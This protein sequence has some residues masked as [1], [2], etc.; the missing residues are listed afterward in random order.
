MTLS[1]I[2]P[3]GHSNTVYPIGTSSNGFRTETVQSSL[4]EKAEKN[5]QLPDIRA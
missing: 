5:V 2:P 4:L 3:N 1:S